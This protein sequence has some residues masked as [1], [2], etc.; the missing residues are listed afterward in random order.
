MKK[1]ENQKKIKQLRTNMMKRRLRK[2]NENKIRWERKKKWRAQ[3]LK[4][5]QNSDQKE[6]MY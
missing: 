2:K 6:K 5:K 3:R 1:N 4:Q